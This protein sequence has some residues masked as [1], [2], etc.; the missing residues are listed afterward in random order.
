MAKNCQAPVDAFVLVGP[1]QKF[2]VKALVAAIPRRRRP[3]PAVTGQWIV[4]P[5]LRRVPGPEHRL[6]QCS[7]G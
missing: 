7:H 2:Q 1:V 5:V 6:S 3:R 4:E